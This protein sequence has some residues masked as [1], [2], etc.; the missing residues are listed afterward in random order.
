MDEDRVDPDFSFAGRARSLSPQELREIIE[1]GT[2]GMDN[3]HPL[4]RGLQRGIGVH[5][6]GLPTKYRQTVEILFRCRY[7]RVV[8]AT[9]MLL[10]LQGI[11]SLPMWHTYTLCLLLCVALRTRDTILCQYA[12]LYTLCRHA[13]WLDKLGPRSASTCYM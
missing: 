11:H 2:W 13:M 6:S 12:L 9:G 5:H 10:L 4:V 7:L 3:D 1:Q 8:I